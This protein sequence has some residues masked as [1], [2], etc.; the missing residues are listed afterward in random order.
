MNKIEIVKFIERNTNFWSLE[1][2]NYCYLRPLLSEEL[3]FS[4]RSVK[5]KDFSPHPNSWAPWNLSMNPQG[6]R[7]RQAKNRWSECKCRASSQDQQSL[8]ARQPRQET[9]S[10]GGHFLLQELHFVLPK[11][12]KF[13]GW[14]YSWDSRDNLKVSHNHFHP[15]LSGIITLYTVCIMRNWKN[16]ISRQQDSHCTCKV[17]LGRVRA[18]IVV[19]ETLW[20]LHIV[21]VCL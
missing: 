9:N 5:I 17:T 1:A 10:S 14:S 8:A 19:V 18:T 6:L 20:V 21:S 12:S 7:G 11:I 4:Y 15:R 3:N 2:I 13:R 16:A